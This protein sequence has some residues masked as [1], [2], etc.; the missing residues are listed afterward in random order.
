MVESAGPAT[1]RVAFFA[2]AGS[3]DG[4][5]GMTYSGGSLALTGLIST[6]SGNDWD[7]GAYQA[8]TVTATGNI[9]VSINGVTY[10]LLAKL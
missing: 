9:S 7:L 5:A 8:A 1:G 4:D 10:R 3:V 2:N 6:A